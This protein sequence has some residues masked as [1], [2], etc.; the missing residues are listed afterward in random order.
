MFW[1][2]SEPNLLALQLGQNLSKTI[3]KRCIFEYNYTSQKK[4]C[5]VIIF[6][7]HNPIQ[8][9]LNNEYLPIADKKVIFTIEKGD[10]NYVNKNIA[11]V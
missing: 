4:L 2:G 6:Y 10:L 5:L 9:S 11:V 7:S 3:S 8:L 1:S